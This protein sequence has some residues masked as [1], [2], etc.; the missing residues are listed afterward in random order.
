MVPFHIVAVCVMTVIAPPI[1]YTAT[2]LSSGE[3]FSRARGASWY[4][5]TGNER[6]DGHRRSR[7]VND[8]S[9]MPAIRVRDL[10]RCQHARSPPVLGRHLP[11]YTA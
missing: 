9:R 5:T 1:L 10:T 8:A 6:A 2:H 11:R 3:T 4:R 7:F